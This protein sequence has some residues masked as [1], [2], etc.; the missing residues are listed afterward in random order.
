MLSWESLD[1]LSGLLSGLMRPDEA[2]WAVLGD[3]R[4]RLGLS[5]GRLGLSWGAVWKP[6]LDRFASNADVQK[7]M[8]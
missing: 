7:I 2:F 1:G 6:I 8:V 4:G 3:P 5:R